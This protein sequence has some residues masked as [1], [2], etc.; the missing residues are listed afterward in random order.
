MTLK[1]ENTEGGEW[2]IDLMK[3]L[4]GA[5]VT[6]PKGQGLKEIIRGF[7]ETWNFSNCAGAIDATHIP[8][9][10]PTEDHADYVNR[11][12]WYLIILQAVCDHRY[13]FTDICIGWPGRVH[14]ARVFA[15]SQ[16]MAQAVNGN[17]LPSSPE[18][19]QAVGPTDDNIDMPVVLIGDAAYPMSSWL[20]KPYVDR[21]RFTEEE[22]TFNYRLSKAR[23]TIENSFGRLKQS[24]L[25]EVNA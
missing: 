3:R 19:T 11:K 6:F 17:L 23:M 16:L 9:I 2:S 12:G 15:N 21:G 13:R 14:D 1:T 5:F 4:L 18:W 7:Q 8:I 25:C 20:L 22:Q 24:F 10:A